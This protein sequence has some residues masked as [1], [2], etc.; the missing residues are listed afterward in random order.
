GESLKS[1]RSYLWKDWTIF[2]FDP[3]QAITIQLGEP[4]DVETKPRYPGDII[5]EPEEF[6]NFIPCTSPHRNKKIPIIT[7]LPYLVLLHSNSNSSFSP[8]ARTRSASI[9]H[10]RRSQESSLI[11]LNHPDSSKSSFFTW[12]QNLTKGSNS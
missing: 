12:S 3:F 6:Y 11:P 7:K 8:K 1:N 9:K 5:H 10:S 4:D 2:R